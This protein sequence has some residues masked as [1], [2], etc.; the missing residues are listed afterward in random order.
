MFQSLSVSMTQGLI[1]AE[2]ID[3]DDKEIYEYGLKT[4]FTNTINF[5]ISILIGVIMGQFLECLLFQLAFLT[6]RAYSGGYHASTERRCCLMSYGM[7]VAVLVLLRYLPEWLNAGAGVL[8]LLAA[9]GVIV[10]LAPV[11]NENKPLYPG[12]I[13]VYGHRARMILLVEVVI[14]AILYFV[15]GIHNFWAVVCGVVA[16]GLSLVAGTWKRGL[17]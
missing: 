13:K 5:L 15:S 4:I 2:V 16:V 9:A 3:A 17:Y 11:E 6:L 7:V 12:E 10:V 14:A 1:Q 8:L